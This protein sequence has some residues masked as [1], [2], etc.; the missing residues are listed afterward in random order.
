MRAR[1]LYELQRASN[2][3]L[4]RLSQLYIFHFPERKWDMLYMY[5]I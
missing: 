2:R 5:C 3:G 1:G 4:I